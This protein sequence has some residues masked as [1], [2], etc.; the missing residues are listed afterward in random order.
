M[1]GFLLVANREALVASRL[2]ALP[3]NPCMCQWH[4]MSL[5]VLAAGVTFSARP[6]R[7]RRHGGDQHGSDQN[8]RC[9]DSLH[10]SSSMT[11]PP[12]GRLEVNTYDPVVR[13]SAD[14]SGRE[15]VQ[16]VGK[17]CRVY[18]TPGAVPAFDGIQDGEDESG[19]HVYVKI[20]AESAVGDPG[21]DN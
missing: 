18:S 17:S 3:E 6:V 1:V 14:S 7:K 16:L 15:R 11:G 19:G 10:G 13:F 21:S 8:E 9:N 4:D 2:V 5:G 12:I 20:S